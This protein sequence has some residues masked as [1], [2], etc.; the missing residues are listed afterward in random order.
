VTALLHLRAGEL[1]L[2]LAPEIGGSIARYDL[3][4]AGQATPLM[5]PAPEGFTEA[6]QGACFPLVPYSN[7]IRDGVFTFGDREVRLRPNMPPQP[8][9]LHGF[10]WRGPWRVV[11]QADASATL[12]FDWPGGEWPWAFSARQ[13]VTL[14][15][16]GLAITLTVEN[17]SDETMPAGLG[18][19]PF[20]PC[21]PGTVLDTVVTEVFPVDAELYPTGREPAVSRYDLRNRMISGAGLDN[22]Y[23]GWSGQAKIRW[24]NGLGLAIRSDERWFQVYAPTDQPVLAAEPVTH[25][26]GALNAPEAEQAALGL[27][28]LAPGETFELT[29]RFDPL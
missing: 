12:A 2:T 18:L 6:V 29:A 22:G 20:Y 1:S 24:P 26:N 9:P 14:D 19:H 28:F 15:D 17:G 7:R 13:T 16:A 5:R 3:L 21:P 10:G 8:H 27:R 23:G 4:R 25:A 11:A